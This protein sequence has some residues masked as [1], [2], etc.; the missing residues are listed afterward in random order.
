MPHSKIPKVA[1]SVVLLFLTASVACA[2]EDDFSPVQKIASN[3][4]RVY[5]ALPVDEANLAQKL[6]ISPAERILVGDALA[7]TKPSSVG[8][9]GMLDTLFLRVSDILNIHIYSFTSTI[10]I[11]RD[12]NQLKDIYY[13]FFNADLNQYSFYVFNLNTIYIPLEYF[14]K[15]ILGHEIAHA[16]INQYFV[17]QPPVKIQ[18][19]L[20]GYVEYQL[21]KKPE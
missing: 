1:I 2:V 5:S 17:V 20:A 16:I 19:I 9:A 21:R 4:F 15:E 13:G 10:K 12:Y 8:L 3:Y 14:T 11:C 18:E 6:N 7:G